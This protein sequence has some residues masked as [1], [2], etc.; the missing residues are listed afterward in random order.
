MVV[1]DLPEPVRRPHWAIQSVVATGGVYNI[2]P[3]LLPGRIDYNLDVSFQGE[4]PPSVSLWTV[5][6]TGEDWLQVT[7]KVSMQLEGVDSWNQPESNY[8]EVY[9]LIGQTAV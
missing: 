8:I 1:A 9:V 3:S 2:V 4:H 7:S 6:Q 5:L